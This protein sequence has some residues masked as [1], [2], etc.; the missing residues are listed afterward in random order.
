MTKLNTRKLK[1]R[2]VNQYLFSHKC[3][4]LIR[5]EINKRIED[6]ESLFLRSVVGFRL[7]EMRRECIYWDGIT[8]YIITRI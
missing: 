3:E 6:A 4:I 2:Q 1:Q 5:E 7:K 8:D